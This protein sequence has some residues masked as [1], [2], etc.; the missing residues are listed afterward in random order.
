M[1][2]HRFR[3]E[4]FSRQLPRPQAAPINLSAFCLCPIALWPGVSSEAYRY[5]QMVYQLAFDQALAVV[6]PS[7]PERDLLANWN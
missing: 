5:Q 4:A 6:R 3:N 2:H 7:L 1:Q